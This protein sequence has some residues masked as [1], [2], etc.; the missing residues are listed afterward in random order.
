MRLRVAAAFVVCALSPFS[1]V[2]HDSALSQIKLRFD[3]RFASPLPAR[4][5]DGG[6][7]QAQPGEEW[8]GTAPLPDPTGLM[9]S[10]DMREFQVLSGLNTTKVTA[11][12]SWNAG[13]G[14][15]YDLD[16]FIDRQDAL[17]NWIQVGS[18][19]DGQLAG[20]GLPTETAE[21][22][23]PTPGRYRTRV[24][25]FASTELAYHGTLGFTSTKS[26]GKPSRGRTT[27]DRP[28]LAVGSQAHAIY[29]VPSD[30]VDQ[31]LDTNGVIENSVASM[32]LWL[33]GQTPGR[34]LRL[35]TYSDRGTPRLDVS[36]VRGNRTTA[37]YAADANGVFTAVTDELEARGWTADASQKRYYVYYEG[38]AEDP[39]ICGTAY[40]NTLGTG[41]AQWSV[42]FL[43]ASPGCGARDFGTPSTGAGMSEAILLQESTHNEGIAR[44]ESL[45]HCWAFQFHIC[46]AVAGAVLDSLDPES[47]DVMFPFVTVPLRNKVLDRDHDDYYE[48]PFPSR[49]LSD[50]PFFEP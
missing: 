44:P 26:G 3:P 7:G 50:S 38:P 18:G 49:D 6:G 33:D 39:N 29:F 28:D 9:G 47:V 25:N 12:I 14:L 35:D 32:N 17:G 30:G 11:T 5:A 15:A 31:T 40:L 45:H 37:D 27:A 16:L 4:P 2:A 22:T 46:T 34:H 1:T 42:V 21:V 19:T 24:V 41:F 43:G 13:T 36:F 20:D 23:A 10:G 48:H 8:D